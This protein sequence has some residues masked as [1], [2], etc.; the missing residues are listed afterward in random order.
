MMPA[1]VT[2]RLNNPII[3][4]DCSLQLDAPNPQPS[5]W[6]GYTVGLCERT[7]LSAGT[8]ARHTPARM[9][10][11]PSHSTAPR[12]SPSTIMAIK[13]PAGSS[14]AAMTVERPAGRC[15]E[16]RPKSSTG[17]VV[18]LYAAIDPLPELL[19]ADALPA[20]PAGHLVLRQAESRVLL[21]KG[22]ARRCNG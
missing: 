16:P 4:A 15:G 6:H 3:L 11:T 12:G 5:H 13:R 21:R 7:P 10:A 9:T 14:A 18:P 20:P 19:Q 8:C 22:L 17:C 2:F 1:P